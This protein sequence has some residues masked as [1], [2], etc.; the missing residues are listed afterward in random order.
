MLTN[1]RVPN[2]YWQ[3]FMRFIYQSQLLVEDGLMTKDER[4]VKVEEKLFELRPAG[5]QFSFEESFKTYSLFPKK[6]ELT[7]EMEQAIRLLR[8]EKN[9]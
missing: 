3:E 5:D 4:K 6:F 8:A 9:K 2:W 7:P 1:R